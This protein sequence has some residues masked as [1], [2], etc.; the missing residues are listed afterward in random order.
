LKQRSTDPEKDST[1]RVKRKTHQNSDLVALSLHDLSSN[2]GE[3]EV[4]ATKVDNLKA[5]GL[6]LGDVEDSL[7]MLVENIE[8]AITEAP[9]E[10]ERDDQGEREDE[11][12]ASKESR[13]K[14]RSSD[15]NSASHFEWSYGQKGKN[16]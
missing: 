6:E 14:R 8:K 9:E 11:F 2:R 1:E 16:E 15:R 4:A 3:K 5:G 10:E 7:E 12:F 13:R